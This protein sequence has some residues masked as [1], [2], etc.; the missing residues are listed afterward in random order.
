MEKCHKKRSR[1]SS[2]EKRLYGIMTARQAA[3]LP[4]RFRVTCKAYAMKYGVER[5]VRLYIRE[6]GLSPNKWSLKDQCV[7][8]FR[9][10]RCIAEGDRYGEYVIRGSS[11]DEMLQMWER[12]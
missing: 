11:G 1:L 2:G 3:R 5:R 10:A 6:H 8:T 9:D 7:R 4:D 12:V